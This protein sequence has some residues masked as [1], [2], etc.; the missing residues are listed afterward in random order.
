MKNKIS[1]TI[2]TYKRPLVLAKIIE[3][4]QDQTLDYS[5]YEVIICDSNS[6]AETTEMIKD[7]KKNNPSFDIS[8]V[9]TRN[10]LA[11]KRNIGILSAKYSVVLFMDDDC[12]PVDA[13]YLERHLTGFEDENAAFT[14]MCGEVRFPREWI[15]TSNYYKFRD[16]EGF[17]ISKNEKVRLDY[18]TIVVMNMSFRRDKFLENIGYVNEDFIGYGMEDQELGWRLQESGFEIIGMGATIYHNELSPGIEGYGKKI[19]HTARDGA[20]TLLRVCPSA[21]KGIN[22]LKLIDEQYPHASRWN[23][24]IFKVGR[25]LLFP[26]IFFNLSLKVALLIER[27]PNIFVKPLYRYILAHYYIKGVSDRGMGLVDTNKGWYA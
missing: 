17:Y 23:S 14:I 25:K 11:A 12:I 20:S 27:R 22:V 3:A 24:L 18:K 9:H 4:L 26:Q 8:H 21:F 5:D 16:Q 6:C 19:Y 13:N 1:V 2:S 10:I 15:N 7:V